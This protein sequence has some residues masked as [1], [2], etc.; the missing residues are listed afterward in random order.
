MAKIEMTI[1]ELVELY[2]RYFEA[3]RIP[4][5]NIVAVDSKSARGEVKIPSLSLDFPVTLTFDS[6]MK[7]NILF[8]IV[9]RSALVNKL[10]PIVSRFVERY[11]NKIVSL[12]MP[13]VIVDTEIALQ[14]YSELIQILDVQHNGKKFLL[15]IGI[16]NS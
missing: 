7:P 12:K 8:K 16:R 14:K 11:Q 13:Y 5:R 9:S 1:D 15:D 6:Y 2:T 4:V 3:G 10:L